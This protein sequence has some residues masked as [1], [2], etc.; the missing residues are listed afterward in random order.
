MKTNLLKLLVLIAFVTLSASC[1]TLRKCQNKFPPQTSVIVKDSI[2]T[3][4]TII[5][6]DK[7][8]PF[9]IKGDTVFA[10][11]KVPVYVDISPVWTQTE[12]ASASA[13]VQDSKLKLQLIQKDQ[14][15]KII[16]DSAFK[17]VSHWKEMY[18]NKE[19]TK[20]LPPEKYVPKIVKFFAWTG[21]IFLVLVIFYV[22]YRIFKP[23][24]L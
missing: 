22:A 1:V 2:I 7:I 17:E 4:D 16:I 23:K 6:R 10:E 14:V 21:G 3:K 9:I 24:I 11:K 19:V 5:Y 8:I 20:V 18:N 13:W 12:Y 15:I